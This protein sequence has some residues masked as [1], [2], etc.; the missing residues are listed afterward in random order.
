[1][2]KYCDIERLGSE[3]NEHI[4]NCPTDEIIIEEKIDGGNGSYD[5]NDGLIH[6]YS[7]NRDITSDEK[8]FKK[9]REF[10]NKLLENKTLNPDYVYYGEW[11]MKHTISYE[12]LPGFIG[13]DIRVKK[14]MDS[15][16][17][18]LFLSYD[19][20]KK[21][22]DR[23]GIPTV[24]LL[25]RG[26]VKDLIKKDI[27][28]FIT[29]SNFAN[30]LMEGVVLKN[31]NRLNVWGR[32]IFAKV[33]REEFKEQNKAT[34]GSIKQTP[35]DSLKIVEEFCTSARIDKKINELINQENKILSRELMKELPMRVIK[36]IFKEESSYMIDNY[37]LISISE[38]K[39][40]VAKLCLNRIDEKL[41]GD[42]V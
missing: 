3:E 25:W 37:K 40:L 7:R 41:K 11:G 31:Y 18:G 1:M 27:N 30:T 38:L 32:Q 33:V 35:T 21:E 24:P 26:P 14:R 22:F 16:E 15:T 4:F 28:E 2:I 17:P 19:G 6:M 42:I 13:Y 9:E 5:I 34:F 12:N 8:T 36:D 39:G 20:M 23:L 10:L 29:K